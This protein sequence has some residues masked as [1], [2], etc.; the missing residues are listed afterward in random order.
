MPEMVPEPELEE[1]DE[2]DESDSE[3]PFTQDPRVKVQLIIISVIHV[4]MISPYFNF[5]LFSFLFFYV[6]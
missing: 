2:F 1:L 6:N 4:F 5:L 3:D